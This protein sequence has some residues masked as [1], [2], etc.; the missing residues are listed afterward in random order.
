MAGALVNAAGLERRPHLH[1]RH[2]RHRRPGRTPR[3]DQ[4]CLTSPF[5]PAWRPTNRPPTRDGVRLLAGTRDGV[6]HHAFT[7]L[8]DLLRPGDL[9]VVNTSAT[10][11]AAVRLDRLALHFSGPL[12]PSGSGSADDGSWLVELRLRTGGATTPYAGGCPGEWFP[13][14]GGATL[15][16]VDAAHAAPVAGAAEHRRRPVPAPPRRPDPVRLRG[17]RPAAVGVPD[18]LPRRGRRAAARRCRAPAARSPR[19]W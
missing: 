3:K 11:P 15:T 16:L 13:L 19:N 1:R 10:L 7:E 9:L 17:P 5:P 18:R 2:R 6:T 14:P 8:P 12:P 4:R